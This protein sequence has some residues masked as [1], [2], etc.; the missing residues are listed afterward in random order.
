[1]TDSTS[2][3]I[4]TIDTGLSR[5]RFLLRAGAAGAVAWTAPSVVG[6]DARALAT[7]GSGCPPVFRDTIQS[8]TPHLDERTVAGGFAVQGSVDVVGGSLYGELVPPGYTNG[9][10]LDGTASATTV[11][12]TPMIAPGSYRVSVT[13]SGDRRN[14]NDN[15]AEV[16]LGIGGTTRSLASA[17]G[18]ETVTFDVTLAAPDEL[19]ITHTSGSADSMGM[20][21]LAASVTPLDCTTV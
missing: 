17:E 9:I 6:L 1:M 19:T 11:L 16:V 14:D 18:P 7:Q 20:I 21:L 2:D 3:T 5:R 13:L 15:S 10:D 8:E 4:D 12:S